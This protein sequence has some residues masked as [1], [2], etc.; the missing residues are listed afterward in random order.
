MRLALEGGLTV[1][2]VDAARQAILNALDELDALS[3]DL[4]EEQPVDLCGVQL[5]HAARQEAAARGKTLELARP[6]HFAELLT[7][8]GFLA[9]DAG[10]EGNFWMKQDAGQ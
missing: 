9:E 2:T 5:I 1:R 4:D 6:A 3:L 7:L 8:G 10:Q